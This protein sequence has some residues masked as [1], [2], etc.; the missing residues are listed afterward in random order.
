ML[1]YITYLAEQSHL[2]SPKV[3]LHDR[4]LP[5]LQHP[6][7]LFKNLTFE[8]IIVLLPSYWIVF[9]LVHRVPPCLDHRN[10]HVQLFDIK[11]ATIC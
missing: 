2:Q 6:K 7:E 11:R 5:Q 8:E 4:I 10:L 9:L 1:L 3:G